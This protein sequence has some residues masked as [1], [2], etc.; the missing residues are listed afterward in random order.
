LKVTCKQ[1][2]VEVRLAGTVWS[3]SHRARDLHR[4]CLCNACMR[5]SQLYVDPISQSSCGST[6][7]LLEAKRSLPIGLSRCGQVVFAAR[8]DKI[9]VRLGHTP[10]G[11]R[12]NEGSSDVSSTA[13]MR[14]FSVVHSTSESEREIESPYVTPASIWMLQPFLRLI[15][16]PTWRFEALG[17]SHVTS[18]SLNGPS[19]RNRERDERHMV[20]NSTPALYQILGWCPAGGL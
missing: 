19:H 7:D 16:S 10:S 8:R 13:R 4:K 18:T 9:I 12:P 3:V 2:I 15:E 5:T 17:R 20:T 1:L 6:A 11:I 14:R